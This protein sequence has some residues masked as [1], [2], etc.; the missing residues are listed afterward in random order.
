MQVFPGHTGLCEFGDL[1]GGRGKMHIAPA[2]L[3]ALGDHHGLIARNIRDHQAGFGF[4]HQRAAGHLDDKIRGIFAG[5]A[6]CAAILP[7]F[8]VV[9]ALIAEVHQGRQVIIRLKHHIAA[10]AAIAAIGAAGCHKLFAVKTDRA[11][12][13]LACVYPNGCNINK[14]CRHIFSFLIQGKTHFAFK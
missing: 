1:A 4:L 11:V 2:A 5:A 13:A 3:A 14:I 6:L 8:G 7:I 9:L 12:A 10:A